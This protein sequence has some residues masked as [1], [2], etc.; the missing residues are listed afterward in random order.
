M[1]VSVEQQIEFF[2]KKFNWN[3]TRG[4]GRDFGREM[5][6]GHRLDILGGDL[7]GNSEWV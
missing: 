3:P 6:N 7:V 5:L 4:F 2:L 1:G